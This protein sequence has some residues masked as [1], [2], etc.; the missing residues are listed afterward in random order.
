MWVGGGL[1]ILG[2]A[3]IYGLA[4][5]ASYFGFGAF[6]AASIF[7]ISTGGMWFALMGIGFGFLFS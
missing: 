2:G 1:A 3:V 5:L 4:G 6:T 7:G